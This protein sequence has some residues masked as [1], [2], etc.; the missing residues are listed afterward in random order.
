MARTAIG[1]S[2]PKESGRAIHFDR[3]RTALFAVHFT[4]TVYICLGWLIPSR[5]ALLSYT[6]LLP[7]IVIQWLLNGGASIVN[8]IENLVRCGQWSDPRNEFE[9]AFF[10]TLLAAA[11]VGAS[12]AQIAT[13]LCSVM[14]IFWVTAL[15]HM[16]LIVVPP[17]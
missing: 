10:K 3:L 15:C 8:N 12:Q 17:A 6:L 9:G 5:G 1:R 13:V 16:V 2:E 4:L 7:L 14:L 11:G